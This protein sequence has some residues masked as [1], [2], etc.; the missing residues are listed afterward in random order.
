MGVDWYSCRE[1]GDTFPDCGDYYVCEECGTLWC[2]EKCA[3]KGGAKVDEDNGSY[4]LVVSCK[5]CRE[6][7]APDSE[8]LAFALGKLKVSR[9]V[10]VKEYFEVKK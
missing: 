10:L 2:S 9:E 1:C 8:L 3:E 5:F 7:Y 6:E 4:S